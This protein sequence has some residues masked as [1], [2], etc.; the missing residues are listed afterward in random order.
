MID[1]HELFRQASEY[2]GFHKKLSVLIEPYLN[3]EWTMADIG[4][5]LALIDFLLAGRVASITAIDTDESALAEVE[6]HIDTELAANRNDAGKISTLLKDASDVGG[7][8]RRWDVVL[9]SF[10]GASI[11]ETGRLLSLADRRGIVI[12]H[13]KYEEGIFDPIPASD[14]EDR[15]ADKLE[16]YLAREGYGFRKSAVDLQFGQPFRTIDDIHEFLRSYEAERLIYSIED[17]II[18]TKRYDFPYYLP[19]N[20]RAAVYIIAPAAKEI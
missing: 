12:M 1:K 20:L 18:K 10:F 9:L 17:R 13:S 4:C 3:E 8:G 16:E 14:R 6:K 19:R 7:D 11:E 2:T 5:G 15:S